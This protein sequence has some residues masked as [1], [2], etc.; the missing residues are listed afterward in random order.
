MSSTNN[1]SKPTII[2][3][4]YL[5]RLNHISNGNFDVLPGLTPL[6]TYG[7]M[8]PIIINGKNKLLASG[9][10]N[11]Y[12]I[13]IG[14]IYSPIVT[15][16]TDVTSRSEKLVL[17]PNPTSGIINIISDDY[18]GATLINAFGIKMIHTRDKY[19]DMT[20][21]DSGVYFLLLDSG[22]KAKIV[23]I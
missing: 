19:L 17:Y 18:E 8:K 13:E 21:Y 22:L 5:E 14:G 20:I 15:S 10:N 7:K 9:S 16:T 12:L 2:T 4:G 11:G 3:G 6:Y 23:K 1:P